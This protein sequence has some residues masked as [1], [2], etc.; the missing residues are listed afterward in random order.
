MPTIFRFFGMQFYF[1]SS[2]HEPIHIHVRKGRALAKFTVEP[3]VELVESKGFKPQE[4]KLAETIIEEN[5]DIV[6]EFW[7]KWFNTQDANK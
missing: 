7:K 3:A 1:W 2:E 4:L 5:R 6:V